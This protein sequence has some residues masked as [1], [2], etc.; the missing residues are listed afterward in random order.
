MSYKKN[1]VRISAPM[2]NEQFELPSGSYSISDIQDYSECNLKQHGTLTD[3]L[4]IKIYVNKNKNRI[5]FKIKTKHYLELLT[6]GT[7]KLWK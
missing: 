1:K 5:T 2:Q 3:N 6:A 4:P 7:I